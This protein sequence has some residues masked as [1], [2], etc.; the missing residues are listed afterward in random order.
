MGIIKAIKYPSGKRVPVLRWK[1]YGLAG[2][3]CNSSTRDDKPLSN[4]NK[5]KKKAVENFL[6]LHGKWLKN[7]QL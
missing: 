3:I 5:T 2:W 7:T 1:K 4:K 6:L